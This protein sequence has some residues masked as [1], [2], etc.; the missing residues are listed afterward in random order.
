MEKNQLI[1]LKTTNYNKIKNKNL[2][3]LS[4]SITF[5]YIENKKKKNINICHVNMI[6]VSNLIL[7]ILF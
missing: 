3:I 4:L 5:I 1:Y 2:S 7:K 6:Q